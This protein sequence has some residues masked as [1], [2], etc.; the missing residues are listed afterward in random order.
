MKFD[1]HFAKI[2]RLVVVYLA[3]FLL[4]VFVAMKSTILSAAEHVHGP[5]V[6]KLADHTCEFIPR[7]TIRSVK[8]V[9]A[10]AEPKN[11]VVRHKRALEEQK[12]Q[13]TLVL[14]VSPRAPSAELCRYVALMSQGANGER[15]LKSQLI[16]QLVQLR[17]E[18]L[19]SFH[20]P[21]DKD[22][23]NSFEDFVRNAIGK[24][25]RTR[26]LIVLKARFD[27]YAR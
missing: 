2:G 18:S 15:V 9:Y 6:V 4:I 17:T 8:N 22:E 14:G 23:Q 5:I 20:N 12:F 21:K 25:A 1:A 3:G 24:Y 26:G 27:R 13:I 11:I 7:G 10:G 19:E 16:R